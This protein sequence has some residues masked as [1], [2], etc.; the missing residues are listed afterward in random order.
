MDAGNGGQVVVSD[1]A[2]R[3]IGDQVPAGTAL[4]D[5]GEHRLKDLGE[6]C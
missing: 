3:L 5:Q 2:R 4:V 6:D 1:M